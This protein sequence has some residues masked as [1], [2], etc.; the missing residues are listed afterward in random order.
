MKVSLA[1]QVVSRTVAASLN[2]LVA[3]GKDCWTVSYELL[4]L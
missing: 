2:L 1:A 3:A 4:Y